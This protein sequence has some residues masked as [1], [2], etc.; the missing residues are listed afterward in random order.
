MKA[1]I[2]R[3]MVDNLAIYGCTVIVIVGEGIMDRCKGQMGI[4][5]KQFFW[6][7]PV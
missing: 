4:V 7:Q 1:W 3:F 5:L 6:S 2:Q